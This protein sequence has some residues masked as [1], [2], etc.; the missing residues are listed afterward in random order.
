VFLFTLSVIVAPQ[1]GAASSE[2]ELKP[3]TLVVDYVNCRLDTVSTPARVSEA[4]AAPQAAVAEVAE[5]TA[6]EAK[7]LGDVQA[8]AEASDEG[9]KIDKLKLIATALNI[10]EFEEKNG[11]LTFYFNPRLL[12]FA[13]SRLSPKIVIHD[14]TLD[15]GLKTAIDKDET[16]DDGARVALKD[17]LESGLDELGD[18]E[19]SL[20]W[21]SRSKNENRAG[22]LAGELFGTALNGVARG[23]SEFLVAK[24][25]AWR[26]LAGAQGKTL[27]P[28][29]TAAQL[30]AL[31]VTTQSV[32][33]D[34]DA[35]VAHAE[36]ELAALDEALQ[37]NH[38]DDL[39]QL[40]DNDPTVV[41]EGSFRNRSQEVGPDLGGASLRWEIGAVSY[42]S[43][44]RWSERHGG[45]TVANLNQYLE[46]AG[47]WKDREPRFALSLEYSEA[48]SVHVAD[49]STSFHY[50]TEKSQRWTGKAAF[51]TFV[52]GPTSK[53][54]L[55]VQYQDWAGDPA[56]Q[57]RFVATATWTQRLGEE[58]ATL[59]GGSSFAVSA[60][61]ASRPEYRGSVDHA[62]GVRAGLKWGLSK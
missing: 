31:G 48:R 21:V 40:V 42:A 35:Y 5:S 2:C 37:A 53:V 50:D 6:T 49:S 58:V 33:L 43:F 56:R 44:A 7:K 59:V 8:N 60:I 12:E 3:E 13:R 11:D 32:V 36:T 51:G 57:N 38:F 17:N 30:A 23:G 28:D 14:P 16:L 24:L 1:V 18:V 29:F 9:S 39:A 10:G 15:E 52:H 45:Q 46:E 25:H 62:L 22:D 61:W 26:E 34:V 47:A 19:Y 4:T 27:E 54:D 55:D 41:V 20:R